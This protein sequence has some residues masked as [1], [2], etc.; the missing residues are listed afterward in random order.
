MHR[1]RAADVDGAE[2]AA[3]EEKRAAG[4]LVVRQFHRLARRHDAADH[5]PV[6]IGE[7]AA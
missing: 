3:F 6:E 5:Q 2:F 4:F 7:S 1:A